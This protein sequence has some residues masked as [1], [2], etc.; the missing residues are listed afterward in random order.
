MKPTVR[1]A[2]S[3]GVIQS[4]QS[5]T[6]NVE[7]LITD[8]DNLQA[9]ASENDF[10][11][12]EAYSEH[13]KSAHEPDEIITRDEIVARTENAIEEEWSKAHPKS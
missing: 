2:V 7:I 6:E 3:G 4:I 12:K 1:I 13:Y 8:Y 10:E 5:T 11:T 9:A